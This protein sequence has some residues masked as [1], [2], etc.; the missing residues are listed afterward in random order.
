MTKLGRRD[1]GMTSWRIA[2]LAILLG[3]VT[4]VF[5]AEPLSADAPGARQE[6]AKLDSL[7]P[8]PPAPTGHI[9]HSGRKQKGRASFYSHSFANRKMADGKRMN[10]NSNVAASKNLP[11][12]SV[13]KVTNLENGKT[14]TVKI[15]DRGPYV[16]GRVVDVAPKVANELDLKEK[17]V[18]SVEVKPITLP[19]PDGEV[20]LGAGAAE[21][22]PQEVRDAVEVS[23]QLTGSKTAE[24]AEK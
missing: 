9:D 2:V 17:G 11:L 3:G 24:T 13:A 15:E 16:N 1:K 22:S 8:V 14:A 12:G 5:A 6:A 18:A 19:Q 20:K 7:P 10:P 4:H 21:A 23:K